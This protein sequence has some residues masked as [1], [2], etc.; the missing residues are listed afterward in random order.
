MGDSCHGLFVASA[1]NEYL[2]NDDSTHYPSDFT[3]V[4][5]NVV[6]VAALDSNLI[7]LATYS[8]M[9]LSQLT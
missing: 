8:I 1:G 6:S 5:D 7:N 2:N 3:R 4:L 9:V